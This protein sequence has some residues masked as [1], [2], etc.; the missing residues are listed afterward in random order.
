MAAGTAAAMARGGLYD[1]LAGGFAR[2]SVD[3]D[4]VVPHFEKM[5]YDNAL[6]ARVYT[7]LWRL[8]GDELARR[9][10]AET[11]AWMIGELRTAEGGF[12][13]ALDADSDGAEGA[14]YVWTPAQLTAEL[15]TADGALAARLFGVTPAGTF[16][17]GASVLQL[18]ADPEDPAAYARVRAALL[19]AR[20][21]RTRPGRDDKVVAAW[22]GLAIAAL[23][24][25]GLALG[26]PEL[27]RRRAG[28]GQ[29]A[30]RG[31]PGRRPADPDLAGR[32]RG[33]QPRRARRLRQRGRGP[34][35]AVRGDRRGPVGRAWPASCWTPRWTGSPG[36]SAGFY[37]TADDSER[38]IYRPADPA[39]GP[40]PS[41]TFAMAG[42]LLSYARADRRGPVP[43]GGRRRAGHPAG[44]GRPLP[45][46]G[47]LGPGRRRGQAG[48]PGRGRRGRPGRRPAHRRPAPHRA[49]RRA[50]GHRPGPGRPA[51]QRRWPRP[52]RR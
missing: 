38:L 2:Y 23:A 13:A 46:G 26:R 42:A 19:A 31:A 33:Q 30:G 9:V 35:R 32:R 24:E 1:Q 10:A 5:L 12:A 50:A 47:G 20:A 40:S 36:G 8:T 25:A 28:R 27:H 16:E 17:H 29:P 51:R 49:A 4:W 15:G 34:D 18:P 45:P 44:A 11:C 37:D 6:L 43:G 52:G 3:G 41:G 22:N 14:F 7:H 21:R 48:R 39:D